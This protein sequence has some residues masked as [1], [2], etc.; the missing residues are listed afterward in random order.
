MALQQTWNKAAN[1]QFKSKIVDA[2][3]PGGGLSQAER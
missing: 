1:H 3:E 2:A